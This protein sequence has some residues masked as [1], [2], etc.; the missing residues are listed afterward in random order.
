MWASRSFGPRK[1]T[2]EAVRDAR[3]GRHTLNRTAVF[4]AKGLAGVLDRPRFADDRHL[5]LAGVLH[6]LLDAVGNVARQQDRARV[7]HLLGLDDDADLPAGLDGVAL[8]D[9]GEAGG[10][11]LEPFE[12]L[13]VGFQRLPAGAR[14]CRADGVGGLDDD[15]VEGLGL[16]Q[17]VVVRY[18]VDDL[19]RLA[20]AAA[21]VGTD[22]GVRTLDL[23]VYGLAHVVQQAGAPGERL[24]Q[25]QLGGDDAAQVGNL[26]RVLEDVLPVG[27]PEVHAAQELDESRLDAHDVRLQGCLV[28]TLANVALH[29]LLGLLDDLFD[30]RRVYAAVGHQLGERQHGHLA[31]DGVE[32]GEQHR[33]GRVVDDQV[34]AREAFEGTD[35]TALPAN[36]AALHVVAGDGDD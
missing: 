13:Q 22:L 5:H 11:A 9:T 31:P 3:P 33:F 10:D 15:G 34:H 26:D 23:A 18:R 29:L 28:T 20:E 19:A 30:P 6:V 17:V 24:V 16:L 8:F 36:G 25:A 1:Y 7:V 12:P 35:V 27:G 21:Q 4:P 2:Q 32:G 14:A